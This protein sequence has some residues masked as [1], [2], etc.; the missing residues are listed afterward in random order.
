MATL[1]ALSPAGAA[2]DNEAD[3]DQQQS[4]MTDGTD[5]T[6]D[7]D[8]RQ[9]NDAQSEC[10]PITSFSP[11]QLRGHLRHGSHG[12]APMRDGGVGCL[13]VGGIISANEAENSMGMSEAAQAMDVLFGQV[14][15]AELDAADRDLA[16]A[17]RPMDSGLCVRCQASPC[18]VE[19]PCEC[20]CVR[21]CTDCHQS[22]THL[23]DEVKVHWFC[24]TSLSTQGC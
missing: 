15:S 6:D 22:L 17:S 3:V 9:S 14:S 19:V 24:R 7:A 13:E 4:G 20:R 11:W 12:A 21:L 23:P 10:E 2:S 18:T 8:S 1:A 5:D 16:L